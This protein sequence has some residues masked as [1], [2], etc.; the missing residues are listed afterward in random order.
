M[1]LE[2]KMLIEKLEM[3]AS[4]LV[5]NEQKVFWLKLWNQYD[6]LKEQQNFQNMDSR[7]ELLI[8]GFT[9]RLYS[10]K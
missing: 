10:L 3:L 8:N 7:M 4:A 1:N 2:P 6:V 9:R 5:T